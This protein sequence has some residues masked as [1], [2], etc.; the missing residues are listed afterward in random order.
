MFIRLTFCSFT[1]A[2]HREARK[3]YNEEIIPVIR[4]Q[5]GNLNVRLLE[6]TNKNH[7][8]ILVTEWKTRYDAEAYE[9]GSTYKRIAGKMDAFYAKQPELKNYYV[10]ETLAHADHL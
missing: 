2:R 3:I 9:A 5:K 8:Y 1:P 7:D 6:P 4:R 10:E